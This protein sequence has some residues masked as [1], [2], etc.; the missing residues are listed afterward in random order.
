VRGEDD[1][2]NDEAVRIEIRKAL[3]RWIE[4]DC[5]DCGNENRKARRECKRRGGMCKGT[6]R[7]E[8]SVPVS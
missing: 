2:E 6:G 8:K 7:V 1:Q 3:T 4:V 5:P